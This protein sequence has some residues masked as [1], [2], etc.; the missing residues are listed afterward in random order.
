M[1]ESN[2]WGVGYGHEK[3]KFDD[4]F[5]GGQLLLSGQYV[6]GKEAVESTENDDCCRRMSNREHLK[7]IV[8]GLVRAGGDGNGVDYVNVGATPWALT[9]DPK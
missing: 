8:G 2:A 6:F 7:W 9:R 3:N 5:D 4:V 1:L